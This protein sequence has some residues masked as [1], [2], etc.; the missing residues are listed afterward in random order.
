MNGT[1][2]DL[3]VKGVKR[4]KRDVHEPRQASPYVSSGH[5][6]VPFIDT[7]S[8]PHSVRPFKQPR[9]SHRVGSRRMRRG[10]SHP[11][12]FPIIRHMRGAAK[13]RVLASRF[14]RRTYERARLRSMRMR[15]GHARPSRE[16]VLDAGLQ[17]DFG[18][19][20]K[21][22]LDPRGPPCSEARGAGIYM[23]RGLICSSVT[24]G[25]ENEVILYIF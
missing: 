8:F 19:I 15:R 4:T 18:R 16:T 1:T 2:W 17:R 10:N 11:R 9:A 3:E 5:L 22:R 6:V 20:I 21:V 14:A 13:R 12:H 23:T 25:W 7:R 24:S